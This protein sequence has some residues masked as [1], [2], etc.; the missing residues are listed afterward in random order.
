MNLSD[1]ISYNISSFELKPEEKLSID[2]ELSNNIKQFSEMWAELTYNGETVIRDTHSIDD[3][4]YTEKFELIPPFNA[5]EGVYEIVI[6][7]AGVSEN[8]SIV[9]GEVQIGER[10]KEIPPYCVSITNVVIPEIFSKN[11]PTKVS[12]DISISAP[13]DFDTS[14]YLSIWKDDILYDVIEGKYKFNE[15]NKNIEFSVELTSDMPEGVYSVNMGIHK[16]KSNIFDKK[17]ISVVGTDAERGQ[18]H[19]PL[20]YGHYFVNSSG[21]EHFWYVNQFGAMI[22]DGEPYIP[23]GGM[24]VSKYLRE[25]DVTNPGKNKLN[26]IQDKADLDEIRAAGINDL[27]IG[28]NI[29]LVTPTWAYKYFIDYLEKTGWNYGIQADT[30]KNRCS[31]VCYPRATERANQFKVEDVTKSEKVTLTVN[32]KF[33]RYFDYQ[34]KALYAVI[35]NESGEL[36]QSGVSDMSLDNDGNI[37]MYADVI[38]PNE[39]K[40]TVYF[41]PEIFHDLKTAANYWDN[42]QKTF[43]F[44]DTV[45]PRL[46]TGENFR[47]VVDL[48]NNESGIYNDLESGRYSDEKFNIVFS[49][50]LKDKYKTIKSLNDSW[51][52]EPVLISFDEASRLIPVYTSKKKDNNYYSY[53]V[54]INTGKG[55]RID[56]KNGLAWNDYLDARDEMYLDFMNEATNCAKKHLNVPYI[57]KHVSVQRKYFI[58]KDIEGGF[59]GL[60]SEA[61]ESV[62]TVAAKFMITSAMNNQFLKTAWNIVTETNNHENV[63]NKYNSGQWSYESKEDMFLRFNTALDLG[64]KGIFDF[65][66]ADRSDN[67]GKLGMAYSWVINEHVIGWASEYNKAVFKNEEIVS[68]L[69]S[70]KYKNEVFYYY[71]PNKNWWSKINERS[72]VQLMDD[73]YPFKRL[74]TEKGIH[75][76]STEDL[77]VDTKV[78]F[79]NLNDK[80]YSLV[81][82]K[83]LSKFLDKKHDDKIICV[84]GHRNDLGTIPEIDIYYTSEK[85]K[86][87]DSIVQV[88]QPTLKSKVLK[89]TEDGKP[90]ALRDGNIY[91]ISTD[92]FETSLGEF[93]TLHYVDD[94]GITNFN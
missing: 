20:S 68:D 14:P 52:T 41:T 11:K 37:V 38:L 46:E 39:N 77:S 32:S 70:R 65:L 90:W 51:K 6:G 47:F 15:Q 94:L 87:G 1:Y 61:Y 25:Y 18:Y 76:L 2:V 5:P 24:F 42:P 21:K 79:I 84:L 8:E 78:I 66:L 45:F 63:M 22:W 92:T 62:D 72:V 30:R 57:Y 73:N 83:E 4:I 7:V 3:S 19:K 64:M 60:G 81:Y 23:F 80:P 56:V 48:L 26:F 50:W 17:S 55:Y 74:K 31:S 29:M 85:V 88:L 69:I 59:D 44:I 58:N 89:M 28:G 35:D 12:A 10:K 75:V 9:A 16:I 49:Q 43:D 93:G 53:F 27:Y 91:I 71:P 86:D 34:I 13:I 36:V 82:G 54:N 33:A 67:Q 40:H